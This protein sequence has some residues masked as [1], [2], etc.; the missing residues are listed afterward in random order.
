[1]AFSQSVIVFYVFE[2]SSLCQST[3]LLPTSTKHLYPFSIY[4]WTKSQ[5]MNAPLKFGNGYVVRDIFP[6][7]PISGIFVLLASISCNCDFSS[8][9]DLWSRLWIPRQIF[10]W[11]HIRKIKN[12]GV[13]R[14]LDVKLPKLRS[15]VDRVRVWV[16]VKLG[17]VSNSVSSG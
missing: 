10:W 12:R 6:A 9:I 3:F 15:P 13:V 17:L 14:R 2:E 1:M 16:R 7:G 8:Q 11:I 5:P 4:I